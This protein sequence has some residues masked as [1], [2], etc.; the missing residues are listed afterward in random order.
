MKRILI[1]SLVINFLH[2]YSYAQSHIYSAK[3]ETVFFYEKPSDRMIT[4]NKETPSEVI[5]NTIDR[6][7]SVYGKNNV[8]PFSRYLY[9]IHT[10]HKD[11]LELNNIVGEDSIHMSISPLLQYKD[12]T[13]HWCSNKIFI[14]L[15]PNHSL[16]D[17]L[18]NQRIPFRSFRQ[19]GSDERVFLVEIDGFIDRSVEYA[20][21]IFLQEGV[22][23]AQPSF[24][25]LVRLCNPYLSDQWGLQQASEVYGVNAF[26][27]WGISTGEGVKVAVI[28][29]GADFSHPDLQANLLSGYDAVDE[30]EFHNENG[31][32][33]QNNS[34]GTCCAGIIAAEDNDIGIKG[35]AFNS[36]IIPIRIGLQ[37]FLPNGW[38]LSRIHDE[39]IVDGLYQ[40][41][42]TLGAD[43]LSNSWGG[44][45]PCEAM[46]TE[47]SNAVS[48]GRDNK[49]CVVVFSSGNY[50]P[51]EPSTDVNFPANVSCD[52]LAVGAS[53]LS[54]ERKDLFSCD[55]VDWGSC[56]GDE[57]DVVAPGVAITTTDNSGTSG[58]NSEHP[59]RNQS[60]LEDYENTDFTR[61]FGGTSA[62]CPYVAGVAALV[63]SVNPNLTSSQV[64]HIIRKTS[65]KIR[66]DMYEY[67]FRANDIGS[68]WNNEMGHGLVDAYQ[69]VLTAANP[70]AFPDLWLRD[71][72][73]DNGC[74]PNETITQYNSSPD[75][76]LTDQDGYPVYE[77]AVGQTCTVHVRLSNRSDI[78]ST[79][80]TLSL[81]W[82]ISKTGYNSTLSTEIN[83]LTKKGDS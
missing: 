55:G 31:A 75:I 33:E 59:I 4:F 62:A 52:I 38:V 7:N 58:Y 27:A 42:S 53:C 11:Y 20:N 80:A 48:R 70:P 3:G 9:W 46:F 16:P 6:L 60:A 77:P 37:F 22:E 49:G 63:L 1:I 56:Y 26:S 18:R 47:I 28:D 34:H 82:G 43:I 41:W 40:A 15:A 35:I 51:N 67:S 25:R 10:Q 44:G 17:I 13:I 66:T 57:L 2:I 81:S 30:L 68:S 72:T 8:I 29:L 14:K 19:I 12:S 74:E 54:G 24:G 64:N 39:W 36:K 71:N 83:P 5:T 79:S 73:A 21:K 32:C 45:I 65:A 61:F 50:Y 23:F 78:P 76:W 69:A